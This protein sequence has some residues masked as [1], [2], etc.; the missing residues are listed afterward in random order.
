MNDKNR[1][2]DFILPIP[3]D[4]WKDISQ[5]TAGSLDTLLKSL[6]YAVSNGFF[7]LA[8][9]LSDHLRATSLHELDENPYQRVRLEI[10]YMK[11]MDYMG[12]DEP[13]FS[14]ANSVLGLISDVSDQLEVDK[15]TF[16]KFT[17]HGHCA[18]RKEGFELEER[19]NHCQ[20][21]V[22]NCTDESNQTILRGFL[23]GLEGSQFALNKKKEKSIKRFKEGLK[24]LEDSPR[25]QIHL[26]MHFSEHLEILKEWR[27]AI[28]VAE[29]ILSTALSHV[30]LKS[31]L[32]LRVVLLLLRGPGEL[33]EDQRK[34][35]LQFSCWALIHSMGLARMETVSPLISQAA[36]QVDPTGDVLFLH[37][38][39]S[40][41]CEWLRSLNWRNMERVV[42]AY[43]KGLKYEVDHPGENREVFDLFVKKEMDGNTISIA[44]QVKHWKT[45]LYRVGNVPRVDLIKKARETMDDENRK[46]PQHF[47]WFVSRGHIDDAYSSLKA[48]LE[49][50]FGHSDLK[51]IN[52]GEFGDML[53][54]NPECLARVLLTTKSDGA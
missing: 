2:R 31:H 3:K 15:E 28:K 27:Q 23:F 39:R 34:K 18:W 54:A 32:L 7:G 36:K 45:K 13:F 49:L 35:Q 19:I 40:H 44:I 25:S 17:V 4:I 20:N 38:N 11:R 37:N 46:C 16:A 47:H 48:T 41:V 5:P 12:Y 29:E 50:V 10:E 43:Y 42:G 24:L 9:M 30:D 22:K 53:M 8:S 6:E 21:L 14:A 1:Y 51:M 33:I 52:L 26:Q